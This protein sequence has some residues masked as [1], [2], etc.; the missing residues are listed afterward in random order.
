[1]TLSEWMHESTMFNI[2]TNIHFFKNYVRTKIF[3]IWKM[4][5]RH[6][7]FC[8]TRDKLIHD[9]FLVKPAFSDNLLEINKLSYDL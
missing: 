6:K 5:V 2:I 1:V 3:N 8:K 4:N 9:C 7:I